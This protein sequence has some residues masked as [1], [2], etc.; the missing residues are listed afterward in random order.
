MVTGSRSGCSSRS[1]G[2]CCWTHGSR[3]HGGKLR[4]EQNWI[5]GSSFKPCSAEYV[6]PPPDAVPGVVADLCDFCDDD[7]LPAIAQAGIARLAEARVLTQTTV[8]RR[9]R[10]FEAPDVTRAFTLLERRLASSTGDTRTTP[11]ARRMPQ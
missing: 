5:G 3:A 8:G 11:P 10:A 6:P 9:N 1:I 4:E 2:A 7:S